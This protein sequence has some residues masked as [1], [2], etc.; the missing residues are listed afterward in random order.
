MTTTYEVKQATLDEVLWFTL[1][2]IAYNAIVNE[3]YDIHVN[4]RCKL[5]QLN[6]RYKKQYWLLERTTEQLAIEAVLDVLYACECDKEN[7]AEIDEFIDWHLVIA[8]ILD[9]IDFVDDSDF[10]VVLLSKAAQ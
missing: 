4:V 8:A 3:D 7:D 9:D 6:E 2:D 5:E 10:E 1:K